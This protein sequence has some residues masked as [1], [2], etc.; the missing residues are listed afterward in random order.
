MKA[1]TTT[2]AILAIVAAMA[3]LSA[4]SA[5]IVIKAATVLDGKGGTLSNVSLIVQGSKIVRIEPAGATATYDLT[6]Q[7]V[8]PGWI[9]THAH[10]ADHFDRATGRLHTADETNETPQQVMLYAAENA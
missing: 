7:T 8:M 2:A 5:P 4:Q 10:L 6:T 9:D 1:V 3:T